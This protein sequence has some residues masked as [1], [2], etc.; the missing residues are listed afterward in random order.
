MRIEFI[1]KKSAR[2]QVAETLAEFVKSNKDKIEA[3]IAREA[4]GMAKLEKALKKDEDQISPAGR[5]VGMVSSQEDIR[6]KDPV[7]SKMGTMWSHHDDKKLRGE[8]DPDSFAPGATQTDGKYAYKSEI[9]MGAAGAVSPPAPANLCMGCGGEDTEPLGNHMGLDHFMCRDCGEVGVT[10]KE[11]NE[12]ADQGQAQAAMEAMAT[13]SLSP[14][15]KKDPSD[16]SEDERKNTPEDDTKNRYKRAWMNQRKQKEIEKGEWERPSMKDREARAGEGMKRR[17]AM[18]R[19]PAGSNPPRKGM[20]DTVGGWV[21]TTTEAKGPYVVKA[22]MPMGKSVESIRQA[23]G[24]MGGT[25]PKMPSVK[26]PTVP[27]TSAAAPQKDAFKTGGM[28]A[29]VADTM[30]SEE[31]DKAASSRGMISHSTNKKNG[32]GKINDLMSHQSDSA[33]RGEKNPDSFAPGASQK[34]GEDAYK[35]E[36]NPSKKPFN[37]GAGHSGVPSKEVPNQDVALES[38]R[39]GTVPP[40]EEGGKVIP[41]PG[42]GGQIKKTSLKKDEMAPTPLCKVADI[43]SKAAAK[44]A[45]KRQQQAADVKAIN[46]VQSAVQKAD[47]IPEAPKAP[48]AGAVKAA[49]VKAPSNAAPQ[50]ASPTPPKL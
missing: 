16:T 42:S 29:T 7:R 23:A 41:A 47:G 10:I 9:P 50:A 49:P 19:R 32:W 13:Q 1:S 11:Q 40:P 48:G 44:Y 34:H 22:S 8:V 6:S 14:M 20:V 5:R 4:K 21:D 31:S 15:V 18:Q 38:A 25:T 17:L 24:M 37:S 3:L 36:M 26:T 12:Q 43:R 28:N 30:K 27:I 39:E 46:T 45:A 33:L 2:R 35:S